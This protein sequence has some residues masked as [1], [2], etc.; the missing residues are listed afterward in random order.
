MSA[1]LLRVSRR[2]RW[3]AVTIPATPPPTTTIRCISL[4]L[5]HRFCLAWTR[6]NRSRL[7]H[8]Q[9]LQRS[10][11]DNR[12]LGRRVR[13]IGRIFPS[14]REAPSRCA[15]QQNVLV[16]RSFRVENGA[17]DLIRRHCVPIRYCRP[18]MVITHFCAADRRSG[19]LR[20]RKA[21]Q[22]PTNYEGVFTFNLVV[23]GRQWE[24]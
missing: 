13:N 6:F 9:P 20:H 22:R 18:A 24:R 5:L 10:A 14:G 16:E 3:V 21:L 11:A 1:N 15:S 19:A 12:N 8:L 7:T 17:R 2:L 4:A 23:D